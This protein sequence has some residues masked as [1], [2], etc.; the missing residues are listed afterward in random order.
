[1]NKRA[2]TILTIL[3]VLVLVPAVPAASGTTVSVV[4]PEFVSGTF[5][6]AIEIAD[7][8]N[9]LSGHFNLSFDQGVIAI[10]EINYGEIEGTPIVIDGNVSFDVTPI[11]IT[12]SV[13]G[14]S[15][16]GDGNLATIR[17]RAV[18][19]DDDST[20]LNLSGGNLSGTDGAQIH[21]DADW[22][23]CTVTIRSMMTHVYV[24]NLDDD[25]LDV[26]LYIDGD[27][28]QFEDR[29]SS[30][31]TEEFG[32]YR[33]KEGVHTFRI[34]WFD[35]DTEKW[36]ND[37][38]ECMITENAA[39]AV[40]LHADLHD[41]D[42]D[43]ISA[44]I[45]TKNLDDDE[46]DVHLYIDDDFIGYETIQSG[47]TGDFG[48]HEFERDE[49]G[50]HP[51]RI[52]WYDPGTGE[53]YEKIIRRYIDSD[54][55]ITIFIDPHTRTAASSPCEESPEVPALGLASLSASAAAPAS[56]PAPADQPPLPS[57]A[58]SASAEAQP[59]S[60]TTF[61]TNPIS[62]NT[63]DDRFGYRL[64]TA[65][66]LIGIVAVLFAMSRFRRP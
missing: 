31:A 55:S 49:V 24:K 57:S 52:E 53:D 56:S 9:L 50:S 54:E 8:E 41:E 19:D 21:A 5:D 16:S 15:A 3:I 63:G 20:P 60:D 51:F 23:N 43:R 32:N 65:Y 25:R 37:T 17:F 46:L 6:V 47:E 64:V 48:L 58:P 59:P 44:H 40:V 13:T 62:S 12:F 42:E 18:G 7:V 11:N 22:V 33:L 4:A 1:M 14:S 35:P 28:K 10:Q 29:I 36:Y 26:Y 45:Y 38:K 34:S 2:I 39:A 61:H 66:I 27:F 30:G